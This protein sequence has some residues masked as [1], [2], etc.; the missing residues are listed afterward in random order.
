MEIIIQ[1]LALFIVINS[2]LKLSFR[3]LWQAVVFGLLCAA[4]IVGTCRWAILQSKT[5]LADF[6][7]DIR[8]MQ[9]A[10]VLVTVES[11][12]CFAFCFVELRQMYGRKKGIW[13]KRLLDWYPGLLLFPVLFYVQTQIIFGMPGTR[14]TL[15]SY[16]L[17]ALVA[18]GLP[19]LAR[20]AGRLYPEKAFRLEV[21]FLVSFFVC[22]TGLITT[23]NGN[24]VYAAV[25][26]PLNINALPASVAAFAGLFLA[27]WGWHWLKWRIK[28]KNLFKH[29]NN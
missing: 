11:V 5:Q 2:I 22:I 14:F 15:I 20:L 19:L 6:L 3:K 29:E 16:A 1:V 21:H 24:V 28:S 17:A 27:G 10:A 9:D 13:W 4:F 18:A 7:N 25:K 12:V 26:A 23:E 8:V